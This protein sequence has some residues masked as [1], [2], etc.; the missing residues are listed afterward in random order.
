MGR[1]HPDALNDSDWNEIKQVVKE[2]QEAGHPGFEGTP[3]AVPLV[4][5]LMVVAG[6]ELADAASEVLHGPSQ[7]CNLD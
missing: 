7:T 4:I 1:H 5:A 2:D 6:K 3:L